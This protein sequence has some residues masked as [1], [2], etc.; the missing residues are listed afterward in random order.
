[1]GMENHTKLLTAS[2][3]VA[4]VLVCLG[5]KDFYPDLEWRFLW[6][7]RT[8]RMRAGAGLQNT[9]KIGLEDHETF[10]KEGPLKTDVPEGI[11]A[12]IGKTPLFKIKS[13]SEFTGCDILAKAEVA[14]VREF[15]A[16]F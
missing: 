13:L 1:M 11:E 8:N 15:V 7:R 6:R 12:C 3:F 4:G 14:T 9:E 16:L 2:A 10:P 5:F